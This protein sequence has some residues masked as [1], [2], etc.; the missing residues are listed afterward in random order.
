M[1]T[2][3]GAVVSSAIVGAGLGAITAKVTGGNVKAGAISGLI[4]GGIGGY[5]SAAKP[6]M[7]GNP[8]QFKYSSNV[9][10]SNQYKRYLVVTPLEHPVHSVSNQVLTHQMDSNK[11]KFRW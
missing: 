4:G 7:F 2:T 9:V 10:T 6:G 5:T 8:A 11:C 3:A 1:T